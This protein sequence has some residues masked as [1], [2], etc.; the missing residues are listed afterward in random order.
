MYQQSSW[1]NL[2]TECDRLKLANMGQF[3]PFTL[4]PL[5]I[6]KIKI[7]KKW[8]KL[9]EI[10]SFYIIVP[11]EVQFL[12][13]GV[14]QNFLSFW[15]IFCLYTP[16]NTGKIKILKQWKKHLEMSSL[17]TCLSKS[18]SYDVCFLRYGIQLLT[19]IDPKSKNLE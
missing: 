2:D 10:S 16:L 4:L 15:A 8:K 7:L 9:L 14:R 12:R 5:K 3:L 11:T 18:Q 13:Y 19:T 1:Y 6:Q 17:Y